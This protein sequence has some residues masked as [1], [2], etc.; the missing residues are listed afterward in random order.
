VARLQIYVV[1]REAKEAGIVG[2][3]AHLALRKARSRPLFAKLL[4]WGRR[5][6]YER[7]ESDDTLEDAAADRIREL[8]ARR[9]ELANSLEKA[10]LPCVVPPYLYKEDTI[11]RFR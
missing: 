10:S 4:R 11:E 6:R 7:L 9:A 1:E 8:K 3:D 5:Y 2:T